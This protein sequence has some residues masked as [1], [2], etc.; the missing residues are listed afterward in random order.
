MTAMVKPSSFICFTL[1][2]ILAQAN[3]IGPKLLFSSP[4]FSVLESI[5]RDPATDVTHALVSD[6]KQD[7]FTHYAV[8]GE[9]A[10]LYQT[11]FPGPSKDLSGFI[12]GIGNG[13][14]LVAAIP[15]GQPAS[16]LLAES[17]DGG[18]TWATRTDVVRKDEKSKNIQDLIV[19]PESGR[20]YVF[21]G[22]DG[23]SSTELR[24]VTR[25]PGSVAFSGESVVATNIYTDRF[26]SQAA[27]TMWMNKP[28]LHV[29]YKVQPKGNMVGY[30]RSN[31]GGA[32]WS[33]PRFIST[34]EDYILMITNIVT[35]DSN[36]ARL[37][38]SLT[39]QTAFAKMIYTEDYG[40]T[41]KG[42][43]SVTQNNANV[44]Y[45]SDGTGVCTTKGKTV[46]STLFV[47]DNDWLEYTQWDATLT[48]PRY[49]VYPM[50]EGQTVSAVL[51]CAADQDKGVMNVTTLVSVVNG[52]R[53]LVYFARE[54]G[55]VSE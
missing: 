40:N 36:P 35:D 25:A 33:E 32:S 47:T 9:G 1:L 48:N 5:Y 38:I 53:Y 54:T 6:G 28:I 46:V 2:M 24:M 11:Q 41:F 50:L 55:A 37:Y 34:G 42:P 22:T 7:F 20:V 45:A 16:I 21:F 43:V 19:V 18:K 15:F 26:S 44:Q 8:S 52:K 14:D 30:R 27:Y 49:K 23:E 10:V 13:K 29:V 4:D 51:D 39:F 12:R 31:N 3:W 17:H